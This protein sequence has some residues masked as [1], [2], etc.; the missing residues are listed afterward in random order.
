MQP[1]TPLSKNSSPFYQQPATFQRAVGSWQSLKENGSFLPS[2]MVAEW[3]PRCSCRRD[4]LQ[5][6]RSK[7]TYTPSN[8]GISHN[9]QKTKINQTSIDGRGKQNVVC[10]Y[11]GILFSVK[12]EGN[13]D[14]HCNRDETPI[15]LSEISQPTRDK[16]SM[17]SHK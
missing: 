9:S 2:P 16:Y 17:I 8:S 11:K 7:S 12:E 15:M 6:I 5:S 13:S 14:T 1:E 4:H 10:P 3:G